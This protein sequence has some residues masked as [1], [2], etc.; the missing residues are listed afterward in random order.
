MGFDFVAINE[1]GLDLTD[2]EKTEKGQLIKKKARRL[3]IVSKSK[4]EGLTQN[5][6]IELQELEGQI[7][8]FDYMNGL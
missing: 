1:L 3:E 5:E 2:W 4:N 7:S 8:M 6:Q